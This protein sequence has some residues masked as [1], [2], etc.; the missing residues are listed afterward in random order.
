MSSVPSGAA[1]CSRA[2]SRS[3]THTPPVWMPTIS[4][5]GVSVGAMASASRAMRVLASGREA[6]IEE[7]L[8]NE[9]GGDGV[10][11]RLVF[12]AVDADR[13]QLGF[14]CRARMAFVHQKNRE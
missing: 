9:L 1:H 10:R 2:C 13:V 4:V 8:Q 7:P 5:S 14:G 11:Q 3:A 12:L 6:C